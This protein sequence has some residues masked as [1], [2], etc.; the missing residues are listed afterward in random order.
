MNNMKPLYMWAGGK[1]KMIQKYE[2]LPSIPKSRY[3][4]FVE[5]FFGGGAMMIYMSK[6]NLDI[7][8]FVLND[9][10]EEIVNIYRTIKTDV[11]GFTQE[12]DRLS[13]LYLP[14][15]KSDRKTFYYDLRNS[16][17]TDYPKWSKTKETATLY[18]LMKTAFNGVFQSTIEAK[19]RFATPAGLLNQTTKVYDKTNVYLWNQFLRNVDIKCGDW[20]DACVVDGRAFYFMDPPYRNSFAQYEQEFNDEQ[21]IELINF[22]K[23]ADE[24]G[25]YVFYCNRETH[26]T[27]YLDNKGKL[28]IAYYDITYTVGRRATNSDGKKEA[29]KAKEVLLYSSRIKND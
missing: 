9:I 2:S 24:A 12:L 23:D 29:K 27:F 21:H 18:F 26:D 6:Q 3:D 16:Y 25:H 11:T 19:G 8:K 7:K 5:P 1:T 14:L 4:T 20:K 10:N 17:I 22:C 28:E 15:Q 13:N